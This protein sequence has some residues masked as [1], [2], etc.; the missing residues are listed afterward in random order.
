MTADWFPWYPALY[1]AD[2]MHLSAAEDGIYRRLIDWYMQKRR[3]LPDSDRALA[4]IARVG[5]D[6]WMTCA[7]SIRPF[8]KSKNGELHHKRCGIELDRQDKFSSKRSEVA[9]KGGEARQ[10]KIK[11]MAASGLPKADAEQ[12]DSKLQAAPQLA[13][14][15]DKTRQEK[16]ET[17]SNSEFHPET[18]H[19][20]AGENAGN[21][22]GADS[23]EVPAFLIRPGKGPYT[24]EGR[25][26]RLN[27]AD[28]DRWANAYHALPDLRAELQALDDYAATK[29][30]FAAKWF[31]SVSGALRNKHDAKL[32]EAK[33]R[34]SPAPSRGRSPTS[35]L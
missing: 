18:H 15:E 19:P 29:P 23:L 25:V 34:D 16:E 35:L 30:E 12:A 33:A 8:F 32:A 2:T 7:A 13:T 1:E 27:Q 3:P 22:N 21:A 28:F 14:V 4:A 5:L 9:K 17:G 6:E 31:F 20:V 10:S 26:I 24:F 11:E